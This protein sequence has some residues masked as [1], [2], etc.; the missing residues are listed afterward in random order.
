MSE[1]CTAAAPSVIHRSPCADPAPRALNAER[2]AAGAGLLVLACTLIGLWLRLR[3]LGTLGFMGDEGFQA[4]AVQGVLASGIPRLDSGLLYVRASPYIY[5]QAALARVWGLNEFTLRLPSVVAGT[6]A[7]P[8]SYALG[9]M[10][11]DRRVGLALALLMALSTWEI[12]FARYARFYAAFQCAFLWSIVLCYRGFVLGSAP[13]RRWFLLAA[14]LTISLHE[15]GIVAATPVAVLLLSPRFSRRQKW[16]WVAW[17][18]A[19]ALLWVLSRLGTALVKGA[20]ESLRAAE[21]L[22]GIAGIVG[23]RWSVAR[24]LLPDWSPL[25]SVAQAHP[26]ALAGLVLLAAAASTWLV[27]RPRRK[28]GPA[29]AHPHGPSSP[30]DSRAGSAAGRGEPPHRVTRLRVWLAAGMIWAAVAHQFALALLLGAGYLVWFWAG[31]RTLA[32]PALRLAAVVV[33]V[34]AAFW[35]LMLAS[36]GAAGADRAR[37]LLL[38]YPHLYDYFLTWFLRGW[39]VMTAALAVGCWRLARRWIRERGEAAS[40]FA[41]G[42]FLVPLLALSVP[43]AR[44]YQAR[45]VFHLYPLV[46]LIVAWLAVE[47][48]SQVLRRLPWPSPVAHVL[49]VS[50]LAL[51]GLFLSQD[52]NPMQAWAIGSRTYQS[53]RD[54]IRG[55][56][57]ARFYGEFHQDHKSPSLYVRQHLRPGE[58]IAALGPPH[59]LVVY[60]HYVGR[61]DHPVEEDVK[62]Y[63]P[64]LADGTPIDKVTG[65]PILRALPQLQALVDGGAAGGVWLL[66]DDIALRPEARSGYSEPMKAYLRALAARPDYVGQDGHTF[67]VKLR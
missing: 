11:F 15:L 66:G 50:V 1:A 67:A 2:H 17:A 37:E 62:W 6:L 3:H 52:A 30:G 43:A 20:G 13:A 32:E 23:P 12:E 35:V 38:G 29:A 4:E 14:A 47:A 28:A 27:R 42:A 49:G 10:V 60:H 19:V 58:V 40:L 41:V 39:P 55:V 44:S 48:S 21:G 33:S 25:A 22:P 56:L 31:P 57:N 7:I 53:R 5:I 51:G 46:L 64:R 18:G 63:E 65:R 36:S 34:C 59:K 24:L 26:W 61:V 9:R 54:P 8:L 45:Y 16:G